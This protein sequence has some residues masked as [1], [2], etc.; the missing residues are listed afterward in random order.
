MEKE[1]KFDGGVPSGKLNVPP[2]S[3]IPNRAKMR[4]NRKRRRRREMMDFIEL[5]RET[6]RLRKED[7]Y[8][9]EKNRKIPVKIVLSMLI[10]CKYL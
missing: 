5:R 6:T 10:I 4:M 8:L 9:E 2:K 1:L 7:Q 3:C